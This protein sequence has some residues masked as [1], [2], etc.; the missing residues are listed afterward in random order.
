MADQDAWLA[1]RI[2]EMEPAFGGALVRVRAELGVAAFGLQVADLPTDTGALAPEHDHGHDG[3][4]EVYL[5]L[6]GSGEVVLDGTPVALDPDTF[7]R[8]GPQ[9]RRRLRGGSQGASVLV[10]GVSPGRVYTPP[11]M[12]DMTNAAGRMFELARSTAAEAAAAL[13]RY[14]VKVVGPHPRDTAAAGA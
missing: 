6:D 12:T 11:P 4:D 13:A 8:I 9:V 1:K 2:D 10:I 7:V 5:L 3:Q 14:D